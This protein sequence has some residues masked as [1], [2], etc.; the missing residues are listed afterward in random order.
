L[1]HPNSEEGGVNQA[2]FIHSGW[3][4]A[5]AP[6]KTDISLT[7]GA[8]TDV[9]SFAGSAITYTAGNEGVLWTVVN[10]TPNTKRYETQ[11]INTEQT[12]NVESGVSECA[13][14]CLIGAINVN[15][16]VIEQN[17]YARVLPNKTVNVI[18]PTGAV[19]VILKTI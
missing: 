18:V 9:T 13:I 5:S 19:A 15:N 12:L 17:K 3:A 8:L 6:N 7:S 16:K 2:V 11:L 4:T 10:P 14:V 1:Q